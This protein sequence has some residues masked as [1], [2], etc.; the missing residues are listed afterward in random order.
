LV[1]TQV[2]IGTTATVILPLERVPQSPE[3]PLRGSEDD[4]MFEEQVQ[5]LKGLRIRLS[6]SH[7]NRDGNISDWQKL[8]PDICREWLM[9]EIVSNIP[10]TT[11]AD[12]LLWSHDELPS[13]SKDIEA[14]AKTPN[15]VVCP[16]A[17]VAYC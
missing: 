5:D 11:T 8:V 10:G 2:G 12:I 4:Q 6:L 9:M 13:L 3:K 14:I 1:Q 17:L 7:H 16:N 15:V